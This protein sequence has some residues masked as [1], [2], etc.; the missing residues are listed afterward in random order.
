MELVKRRETQEFFLETT[1]GGRCRPDFGMSDRTTQQLSFRLESPGSYILTAEERDFLKGG[2]IQCP[3]IRPPLR[4]QPLSLLGPLRRATTP[5]VPC[6]NKRAPDRCI[7]YSHIV[8]RKGAV[9]TVSA[10]ICTVSANNSS[11]RVGQL[12]VFQEYCLKP[13]ESRSGLIV[14]GLWDNRLP[15]HWCANCRQ[16][17]KDT[18]LKVSK[19]NEGCTS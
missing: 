18:Y 11:V 8:F 12:S 10:S 6:K 14:P 1:A 7:R 15:G 16:P 2:C 5:N 9:P 17:S 3:N 4:M 13:H 19:L